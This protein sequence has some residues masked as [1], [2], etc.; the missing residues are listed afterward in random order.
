MVA[1]QT[2]LKPKVPIS[3]RICI[4][5][6]GGSSGGC[7]EELKPSAMICL[8]IHFKGG[9]KGIVLLSRPTETK[10][11]RSVKMYFFSWGIGVVVVLT[12]SNPNCYDLS[13]YGFEGGLGFSGPDQLKCKVPISL[14]MPMGGGVGWLFSRLTETQTA[15]ICSNMHF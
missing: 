10:C 14:Q 4:F 8:N 1:V 9:V 15:M 13:K 6:G 5:W 7:P 3:V 2:K 12:N 11:P